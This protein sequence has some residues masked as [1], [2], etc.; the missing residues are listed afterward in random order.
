MLTAVDSADDPRDL[1]IEMLRAEVARLREELRWREAGS[2]MH[3]WEMRE[4]GLGDL[5]W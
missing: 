2:P 5:G 3:R 4:R 1:E